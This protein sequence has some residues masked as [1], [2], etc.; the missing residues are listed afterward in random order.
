MSTLPV[1]VSK[2]IPPP[3]PTKPTKADAVRAA[4]N[5]PQAKELEHAEA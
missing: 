2:T 5:P 4:I 1:Q 3:K